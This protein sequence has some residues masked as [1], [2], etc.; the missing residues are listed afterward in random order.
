MSSPAKAAPVPEFK[1]ILFATDFSPCSQVALP[2]ALSVAKRYGSTV[3]VVHV[4]GPEPLIGPLGVH[5]PKTEDEDSLAK[6]SLDALIQSGA[7][8]GIPYTH[9]ITRGVVSSVVSK[10]IADL[11]ID[12]VV[13][14]THGRSGLR[15]LVL[16]SVA[17]KIL[18]CAGCP[19][20]TVGPEV[21]N[22]LAEG[23]LNTIVYATD[24]SPA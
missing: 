8:K 10:Q 17:E 19:A 16:G 24:F 12:L 15:K 13:L 23:K 3:H 20:L 5:Y 4:V 14:G 2:Y 6:Q 21:H 22:G 18:R 1:H 11:N 7:L 9:T